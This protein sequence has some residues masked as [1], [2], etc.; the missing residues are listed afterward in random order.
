MPA[1]RDK[2]MLKRLCARALFWCAPSYCRRFLRQGGALAP[3]LFFLARV[4]SP[5]SKN[6]TVLALP[7]SS[8]MA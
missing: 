7:L 3:D 8:A 1:E 5:I 6:G 2:A 4:S